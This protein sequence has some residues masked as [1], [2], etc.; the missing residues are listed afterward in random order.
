[1]QAIRTIQSVEGGKLCV[2]LP[3]DFRHNRVE[4]IILPCPQ[5]ELGSQ[6]EASLDWQKDFLSI[7]TWDQTDAVKV[8]SWKIQEF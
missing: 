8:E 3:P 4:V 6:D 5:A 2:S 7:S 1:M